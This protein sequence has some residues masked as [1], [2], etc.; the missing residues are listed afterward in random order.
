MFI[1]WRLLCYRCVS[2]SLIDDA[3]LFCVVCATN[4]T[5]LR[6]GI[7]CS[8]ALV[9]AFDVF[10]C[11]CMISYGLNG[12]GRGRHCR[13]PGVIPSARV[14]AYLLITP[15]F[16]CHVLVCCRSMYV[17]CHASPLPHPKSSLTLSV[18]HAPPG[19]VHGE[20]TYRCASGITSTQMQECR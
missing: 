10:A 14:E 20:R 13:T 6:I 11:M 4:P 9:R 15:S 5:S 2:F 3:I 8:L 16:P 1:Y 7:I 12:C 18:S 19:F 17:E